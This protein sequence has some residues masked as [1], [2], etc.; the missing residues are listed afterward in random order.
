[1]RL[2]THIMIHHSLT[3]D[4][5]TVSWAAIEKYHREVNRWS[6]IGYHAGVENIT[7]DAGLWKYK[8]Q[9][10][11]GR[12][13]DRFAA[14]CPQGHMNNLALHVCCIGNYDLGPPSPEL[15]KVLLD[16]IILPWS[17]EYGIPPENWVGH[18]DFN[19][20]KSCPGTK[21]D[22]NLLREMGR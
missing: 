3:K 21:F 20:D 9:A 12:A 22:L 5:G 2:P 15:L 11:V 6:D 19:P 16:R 13:N 1:M 14:A 18:R 10:L 17:R 8:Y 7:A 4:S